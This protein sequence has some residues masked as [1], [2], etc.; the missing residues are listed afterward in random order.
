MSLPTPSLEA[1]IVLDYDRTE[2]RFPGVYMISFKAWPVEQSLGIPHGV[3]YAFNLFAPDPQGEPNTPL[4]RFDNEHPPRGVKHPFD[5]WHPAKRGPGGMPIGVDNELRQTQALGQLP[6]LFLEQS[7]K[8]LEELG[9]DINQFSQTTG[10]DR[11]AKAA[12]IDEV[13]AGKQASVKRKTRRKK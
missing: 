10:P 13:R 12:E 5:H 8:L 11:S 3:R 4:L 1:Q 2:F 9:V 7:Y 6:M